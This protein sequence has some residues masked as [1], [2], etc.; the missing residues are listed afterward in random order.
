MITAKDPSLFG[1]LE[2]L[3]AD[4]RLA[5]A[6][7]TRIAAQIIVS[8]TALASGEAVRWSIRVSG[9]GESRELV[10]VGV[11]AELTSL[12]PQPPSTAT[13]MTGFVC[14]G[15]AESREVSIP[16]DVVPG[17]YRLKLSVVGPDG[18]TLAEASEMVFVYPKQ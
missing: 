10:G 16:L 17:R 14:R 4:D 8:N 12:P 13:A 6:G 11:C 15:P 9:P 1:S 2:F 7:P 3:P 5:A 18:R